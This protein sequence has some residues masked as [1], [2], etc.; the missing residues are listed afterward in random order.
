MSGVTLRYVGDQISFGELAIGEC[1]MHWCEC[2][3]AKHHHDHELVMWHLW[4]TAKR[5]GLDRK[6]TFAIPINLHGEHHDGGPAVRSW[7]LT[8]IGEGTWKVTPTVN[9][10]EPD[11]EGA[12]INHGAREDRTMFHGE[13]VIVGVPPEAEWTSNPHARRPVPPPESIDQCAQCGSII[14][15]DHVCPS[16]LDEAPGG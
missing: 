2:A 8:K 15:G 5:D 4:I 10:L 1:S 16:E 3:T 6:L 12:D 7:G 14:E 13:I 9:V 11:L